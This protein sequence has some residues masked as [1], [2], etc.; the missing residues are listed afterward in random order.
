MENM[1]KDNR[2]FGNIYKGKRVLVT[3]HT[4]FKGSWLAF[5]LDRLG[6]DVY[7][8][9]LP[10]PEKPNHLGLLDL[11]VRER[12]GNIVTPGSLESWIREVR[13]EIV[14]HLA[15]Q[16]LVRQSYSDPV[17]TISTNVLGTT[18]L[19]DA[20]RRCDSLKAIVNVTS[21]KCYENREWLWGYREN[22]PLGGY[23][24]YSASKACAE[25]LTSSWRNSYLPPDKYGKSHQVLLASARAGNVIGGGDWAADRL[26]P[27]MVKATAKHESVRI[28]N[29]K[30]TRP[31]QHVLE[32]L[33]GYLL[34]GWRL[35]EEKSGMAQA[36]NF[37]PDLSGNLSVGDLVRQSQSHWEAIRIEIAEDPAAPH[38][39]NFLM[40][41][42]TKAN[43]ELQWKPV[44]SIRE[45]LEMTISW[46]RDFYQLGQIDTSAQLDRY[47][48][49]AIQ[50]HAIWTVS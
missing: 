34:L 1:V 37:G 47:L 45:T 5:W 9:S 29:P 2:F 4:G 43:R 18:M 40:L 24:P 30:A 6:A 41:D 15:A 36:W 50:S 35:L 10:D 14:F 38:E 39:A 20:C 25:I 31:W 27:D 49:D 3:G 46:Y 33:S 13:P 42:C 11:P 12:S 23:D 8:F 7:G 28:R 48:S 19:F 44:W 21:D 32:P 26:I 22:E 16:A 17:E